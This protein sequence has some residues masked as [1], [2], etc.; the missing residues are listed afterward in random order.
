MKRFN[1]KWLLLKYTNLWFTVLRAFKDGV[2]IA[3]AF[4]N[5]PGKWRYLLQPR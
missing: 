5:V 1:F 3:I 2:T 4:T